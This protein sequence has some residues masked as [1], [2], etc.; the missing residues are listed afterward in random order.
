MTSRKPSFDFQI[1]N[2]LEWAEL[3][4]V[5]QPKCSLFAILQHKIYWLSEPT[6]ASQVML[7]PLAQSLTRRV[8]LHCQSSQLVLRYTGRW[9]TGKLQENNSSFDP[10][11]QRWSL[12]GNAASCCW[13][14]LCGSWH[15]KPADRCP[16][17]YSSCQSKGFVPAETASCRSSPAK[18]ATIWK[19]QHRQLPGFTINTVESAAQPLSWHL[20]CVSQLISHI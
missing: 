12:A 13:F 6:V 8:T 7:Q 5:G 14:S 18:G 11:S 3:V 19:P 17:L 4:M 20:V 10:V 2:I 16:A 9:F 1:Q 15:H